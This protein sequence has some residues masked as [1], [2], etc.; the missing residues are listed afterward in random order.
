MKEKE[1]VEEHEEET[2]CG[3]VIVNSHVVKIEANIE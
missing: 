3:T 1:V 2:V